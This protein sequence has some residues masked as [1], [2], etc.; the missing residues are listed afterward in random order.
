M[1]KA[2]QYLKNRKTKPDAKLYEEDTDAIIEC[3][4]RCI[5]VFEYIGKS[6]DGFR[7]DFDEYRDVQKEIVTILVYIVEIME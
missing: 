1:K 2:L 7:Y 4:E 5:L 3:E 6:F